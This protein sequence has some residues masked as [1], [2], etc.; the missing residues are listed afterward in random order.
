[1]ALLIIPRCCHSPSELQQDIKLGSMPDCKEGFAALAARLRTAVLESFARAF[2]A[3]LYV[4]GTPA[5]GKVR[6]TATCLR[7]TGLPMT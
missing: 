4:P 6:A 5:D 3:D 7:T 1:M 2:A